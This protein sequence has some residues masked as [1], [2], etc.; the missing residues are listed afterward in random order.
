MIR[1]QL[2]SA[3]AQGQGGWALPWGHWGAVGLKPCIGL[4]ACGRVP[5]ERSVE[6]AL[7]EGKSRNNPRKD[8]K[9]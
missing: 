1:G 7:Q 3:D 9:V 2:F 5:S 4:L 8:H 6:E